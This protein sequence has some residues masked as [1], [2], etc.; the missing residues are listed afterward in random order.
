M[1]NKAKKIPYGIADFKKVIQRGFI[2]IDKTRYVELLEDLNDQCPVCLRPRKFGKTLFLSMLK[3][4]YDINEK[5]SFEQLFSEYYI[6]KNP[7]E[8][9]NSYLVLSFNFSGIQKQ[10]FKTTY[11]GFFNKVKQG[12]ERFFKNYHQFLATDSLERIRAS[13]TP[14]DMVMWL[15]T[16][17]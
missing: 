8:F 5:E 14:E 3:Y 2:Y 4:Y 7:T 17:A 13:N 11:A 12:I 15:F 16:E 9:K 6:G 1:K 10:I